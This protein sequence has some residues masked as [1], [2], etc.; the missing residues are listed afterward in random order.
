MNRMKSKIKSSPTRSSAKI[1]SG[2]REAAG[3]KAEPPKTLR[4]GAV[5]RQLG[6]SPSMIRSWERL[7]LRR[8]ATDEGQHR[9]YE[10]RDVELLCRAVYLRRVQGL[11]APA[12]IVQ[13][14]REG[15]LPG[16]EGEKQTLPRAQA[17]GS[18]LRALRLARG[19]SLST[20]AA[21]VDISTGFLSNLERS[22]TGVSVGIMHRLAHHYGTSLSE[23]YYQADSPG[24]M[25]PKDRRRL[26]SDSNGVRMEELAWGNI[27]M[28]PHI[29]HVAP[30]KG[31]LEFYTHQGQ[32]FLYLI[33]GQLSIT[34]DEKEYK[35]GPGDSF[36]FESST[37][38]R[39]VN[40]GKSEAVVVWV[41]TAERL[42]MAH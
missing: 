42:A 20:V 14:R 10:E 11:N 3:S 40:C 41:N 34:L 17:I 15:L 25:V 37:R 38:H 31:S 27:V 16:G 36:Y 2:P 9:L 19:E 26:L 1:Q 13:L 4:I 21:A 8:E 24:P 7:G 33:K 12:I 5:A 30:G 29:F 23:F 39:W 35:L 22:Q 6:I 32:E 18:H 28:E